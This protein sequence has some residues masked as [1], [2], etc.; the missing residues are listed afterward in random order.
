METLKSVLA[1]HIFL[2]GLDERY[3]QL[4]ESCASNVVF[5]PGEF[6]FREGGEADR[7]YLIRQGKVTLEIFTAERGSISVMTVSE[8]EVL[9]WSWLFPPYKWSFDARATE[10]TRA[11]ALDGKCLRQKCEQDHELGYELMKRMVR[12][13]EQRLQ[14]TRLQLLNVYEV[15]PRRRDE[16]N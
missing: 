3:L 1:D 9:G 16:L 14:A 6:V 10:L 5:K 7:F 4:M 12:V 13:V 11:V 2:R 15:H 8:G